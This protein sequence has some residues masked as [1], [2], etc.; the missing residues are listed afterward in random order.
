MSEIVEEVAVGEEE[1]IYILV[2]K[3]VKESG[4]TLKW[5]LRNFAAKKLCILHVHQP[6]QEI[7]TMGTKFSISLVAKDKVGDY[8]NTERQHMHNLLETY[9]LIC[10]RAGARAEKLHIERDSIEKGIVELITMHNIKKLVMGAA[11]DKLYSRKMVEPKSKKSIYVCWKAPDSCHIWYVCNGNLICI[12]RADIKK[13]DSE[14]LSQPLPPISNISLQSR[15]LRPSIGQEWKNNQIAIPTPYLRR[16]RSAFSSP[17]ANGALSPSSSISTEGNFDVW[18]SYSGRSASMYSCE[19]PSSEM[20]ADLSLLSFARPEESQNVSEFQAFSHSEVGL[21]N[22]LP[23]SAQAKASESSYAEELRRRQEIEEAIASGKEEIEKLKPELDEVKK[24]LQLVL[25]Q[26]SSLELKVKNSDKMMEDLEQKIV[27][28]V[29]LLQSYKKEKDELLVERDNALG[30]AEELRKKQVE[31]TSIEHLTAFCVEFSLKEIKEATRN[32]D[33]ALKIGEG[34]Y[35]SIYRGILRH[36][37]VAIKVLHSDS[38]QGPSEFEREVNVLSKLRHPNLITLIGACPAAWILVYEYLPNGSLEDR[39]ICKYNTPPLSWQTRVRIAAELCSVVVFLHSCKPCSIIHGDLKPANILLDANHV[40]KLSD[41]GICCLISQDEMSSNKTA[42]FRTDYPKGTF[43]YI[44]PEYLSTGELTRKSDVYSFGIILLRL[45][46]GRPA[47]GIANDV[48]SAFDNGNLK[49]L[50]DATAGDWPFVRAKQLALLALS[51]CEMSRKRRP[52][53]ISEVWRMLEP[54]RVSCGASSSRL[55]SEEHARIP[56][57]YICPIFQEIMQ[58]P[59]V[60]ADGYTYEA[61][62]IKGWLESENNKSPMTGQK[63]A[64]HVLVPNHVL[65][66]AIQEWLH[67][68]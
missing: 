17:D 48:Q 13:D 23:L 29:E 15:S 67:R 52:D 36:S 49:D 8:H 26:K 38:S 32:F 7:P 16:I 22:L 10:E 41:F 1:M 44:D 46:T 4:S 5:A 19:S 34:G 62:A 64:N 55:V 61:E 68:P 12:R 47:L 42:C 45:L 56:Q 53:L 37:Q 54:M 3:D 25:E 20:V 57:L 60:A 39:L 51:C 50:L 2:G 63:L 35:G 6:S 21:S 30:L 33:P 40:S 9:K 66:S 65:H 31:Y 24:E 28:A 43:S 59:V 11:A 18:G 27:L 14:V 58:D